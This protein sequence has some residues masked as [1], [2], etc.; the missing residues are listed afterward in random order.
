MV[1]LLDEMEQWAQGP[2]SHLNKAAL[3]FAGETELE[4]EVK[5]RTSVRDMSHYS[6]RPNLLLN[7]KSLI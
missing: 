6:S 3:E 7:T 1:A 2:M 5:M 4:L